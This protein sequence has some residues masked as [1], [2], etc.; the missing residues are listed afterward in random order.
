MG[1]ASGSEIVEKMIKGLKKRKLAPAAREKVYAILIPA[2]YDQDWDAQDDVL[3]MDSSFDK[4][5]KR[6][7]PDLFEEEE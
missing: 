6:I 3:G 2:M 4:V 1:W 7:D 5:L